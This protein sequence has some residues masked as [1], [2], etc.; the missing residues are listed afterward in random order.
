M[1]DLLS[2]GHY[3]H[4]THTF[5]MKNRAYPSSIDNPL[6]VTL[7]FHRQPHMDY[8]LFLQENLDPP[9]M[10]FQKSEPSYK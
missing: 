2:K 4:K 5:L 6:Y 10:I 7:P 8:T 1:K 9:F 3:C